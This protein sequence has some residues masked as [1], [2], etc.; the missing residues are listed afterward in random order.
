[1]LAAGKNRTGSR[2]DQLPSRPRLWQPHSALPHPRVAKQ[3]ESYH[4]PTRHVLRQPGTALP[5]AG[6]PPHPHTFD[7]VARESPAGG[8]L[9]RAVGLGNH[10]DAGWGDGSGWAERVLG[11]CRGARQGDPLE[12][13]AGERLGGG[14]W[15]EAAL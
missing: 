11:F 3:Y 8:C 4:D 5:R 7:A 9:G 14:R 12:G 10:K 6:Q 15:E 2:V 13:G 1:M